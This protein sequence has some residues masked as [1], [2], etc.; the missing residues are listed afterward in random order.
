MIIMS[1]INGKRKLSVLLLA[2]ILTT[3][4]AF[5]DS[6]KNNVVDVKINKESNNAVKVTIYTD[7]PY[8]EPVVVNKKA[9]NKY[10]ILMPE[11]KSN[12]K[13]AP[14]MTNV[15]GSVSNVTVNTQEVSGGK[16][17]T[18]I[19]ITSDKAINIVPRTQQLSVPKTTKTATSA[20][21]KSVTV[22]PANT[23]QKTTQQPTKTTTVK[24]KQQ[25]VKKQITPAKTVKT[26]QTPT[27]KQT[28]KISVNKAVQK[29]VPKA[30]PVQPAPKTTVKQK[31]QPIEVLEQEVK[32]NKTASRI[33]DNTNDE[34]L[35]KEI[36]ENELRQKVD[37]EEIEKKP[38]KN[39]FEINNVKFMPLWKLIL[40]IGAIAFPIIVIM[41]IL[42]MDKKINRKID[43]TIKREEDIQPTY[44]SYESPE[45]EEKVSAD[46]LQ[47]TYQSVPDPAVYNSFDDMLDKVETEPTY[48]E[49]QFIQKNEINNIP[50]ADSDF[51]N[52]F[53]DEDFEHDFS[54][55]VTVANE[56]VE[57]TIEEI[58]QTNNNQTYSS[59]IPEEEVLEEESD[60][61]IQMQTENTIPK[62]NPVKD[63]SEVYN[64]DGYLS[65]FSE[66]DDKD[67][68]DELTMQTMAQNNANG[69]PEQLPADE[70]FDF[71]TEDIPE[72]DPVTDNYD[73]FNSEIVEQSQSVVN[74]LPEQESTN[75]DD[76]LTMLTEVKLNDKT[77]LYLVNYENFSSLVGHIDDDYFVIK[78]FDDIVNDKIYLKETE[79]LDS[80]TRYLV[81]IGKNKMVVEVSDTSMSRLLDL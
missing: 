11:T 70:I 44:V 75:Y 5:A 54:Q 73:E 30:V 3:G 57:Q 36:K 41:L 21:N 17:Y 63:S 26:A 42:G 51:K 77:G 25:E 67:F 13:S 4:L 61:Y 12:L 1:G 9:N 69:L 58:A 18:K 22:K 16:G 48:H 50:A 24:Q 52:D 76:N 66:I 10:V 78:K 34:I 49:E 79:K 81:R 28:K 43:K 68:F 45:Q 35:N 59:S 56:D 23:T 14:T 27:N 64:P 20:D 80:T 2:T 6:Y 15:S 40:L 39:Q 31:P 53:S 32:T 72:K 47:S 19:T 60:D 55:E 33:V 62:E 29:P 71:M 74:D 46:S 8:T 7:R 38:V 37:N 65:D